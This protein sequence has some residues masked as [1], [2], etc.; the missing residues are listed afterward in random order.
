MEASKLQHIRLDAYTTLSG[1]TQPINLSYQLFGRPLH[2]APVV[3]VN[4]ALTGNSNVAGPDGWW[5]TLV[6]PGRCIDTDVYTVICF[7]VPGNGYDGFMIEN[8]KDFVAADI[9]RIFLAG[10]DQLGVAEL[11]KSYPPA[12]GKGVQKRVSVAR[13]LALEPDDAFIDFATE[14]FIN[15]NIR[16]RP[17]S[18]TTNLGGQQ[19]RQSQISKGTANQDNEEAI[20]SYQRLA[21]FEM[22]N[23]RK[24]VKQK[25]AMY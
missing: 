7:N 21:E 25:A 14:D 6:G 3:L 8:Y 2:G 13:A 17:I 16:V 12:L 20:E 5:S 15:K 19:D 11:A 23:Q 22:D 10:L 18:G 24:M 1:V 4:H 9:A